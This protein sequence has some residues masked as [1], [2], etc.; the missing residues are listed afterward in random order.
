MQTIDILL[1]YI[2]TRRASACSKLSGLYP[3][4]T[5]VVQNIE[6]S[7]VVGVLP[8]LPELSFELYVQSFIEPVLHLHLLL[9]MCLMV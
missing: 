5:V 2:L 9:N 7:Y 3:K 1:K 6:N 8:L 4:S